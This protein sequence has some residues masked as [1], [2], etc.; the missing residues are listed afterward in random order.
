MISC[1]VLVGYASAFRNV[2]PFWEH[3]TSTRPSCP[4]GYPNWIGVGVGE[5]LFWHGPTV[6]FWLDKTCFHFCNNNRFWAN[7]AFVFSSFVSS[8]DQ[9]IWKVPS[10]L[11]SVCCKIL[12]RLIFPTTYWVVISPHVWPVSTLWSIC[13]WT[14][15]CWLGLFPR[16]VCPIWSRLIWATINWQE[17]LISCLPQHQ[18]WRIKPYSPSFVW[19][20]ISL[21][22]LCQLCKVQVFPSSPCRTIIWLEQSP[23]VH[24][25]VPRRRSLKPSKWIALRCHA[26]VAPTVS[27]FASLATVKREWDAL[28]LVTHTISGDRV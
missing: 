12:F 8:Q 2:S 27:L 15:T 23:S 24:N 10:P 19:I 5:R 11:N 20:I 22:E 14:T 21:L 6:C 9:I 4:C 28:Y 16:W 17:L 13:N 18:S 25:K 1:S 26:T 7:T 3:L